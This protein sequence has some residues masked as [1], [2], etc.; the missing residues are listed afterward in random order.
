MIA[1]RNKDYV[2]SFSEVLKHPLHPFWRNFKNIIN[3]FWTLLT[4][5]IFVLGVLGVLEMLRKEFKKGA[6]LLICFFLPLLAQSAV[7][8]VFTA[9]YILFSVPLF[10]IFVAFVME[11]IF[12]LFKNKAIG[13]S[14]LVLVL[15]LPCYQ[16]F[17]LITNPTKAW[18]PVQERKGYLEEWTAG[19]GIKEAALYLIKVAQNQK[20]L[21]GTEGFF[22]TLPDG[23]QIY[24]EKIPNITVIGVGYPIKEIPEKL[25]NALVDNRVFLLVNDSRFEVKNTLN[26]KLISKYPKAEN[27]KTGSQEN[28]LFFEILK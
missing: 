25:T 3:W 26:L 22:G 2:F 15:L 4:P 1:I 18:L 8:K 27:P 9:R 11:R 7:A 13:F 20:V 12:S 28:L 24:L 5:P 21:A 16:I 17:L 10:L 19:Y 6:F 23:L 14:S